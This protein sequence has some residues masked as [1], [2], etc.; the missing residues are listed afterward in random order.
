MATP[1]PSGPETVAWMLLAAGDARSYA[2]NAGYDDEPSAYYSWDSTVNNSRGPSVGDPVVLWDT[3]QLLGVSVVEEIVQQPATKIVRRCPNCERA[4]IKERT[5]KLPRFRCEKCTAEFD[6]PTPSVQEVITYKSRHDAGW[7]PLGGAA[8]ADDL[9]SLTPGSQLS[10]RRIEWSDF[11]GLLDPT[12]R[13]ERRSDECR[14]RPSGLP[15]ALRIDTTVTSA[16]KSA[17]GG[18]RGGSVQT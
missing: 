17:S 5:T 11:L 9:R 10:I 16:V 2:G 15:N 7:S 3:D 6:E 14:A 12:E 1:T 13:S 8:S 18:V 4:A